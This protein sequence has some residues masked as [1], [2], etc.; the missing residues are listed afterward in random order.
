MQWHVHCGASV[1]QKV[2]HIVSVTGA[3]LDIC[4]VTEPEETICLSVAENAEQHRRINGALKF[5]LMLEKCH[6]RYKKELTN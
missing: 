6:Q 4:S 2:G 1:D 5:H 3:A